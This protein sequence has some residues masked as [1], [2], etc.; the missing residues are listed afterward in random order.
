[1]GKLSFRYM[2]KPKPSRINA[3]KYTGDKTTKYGLA[4]Q[5]YA[6]LSDASIF[7]SPVGI[8]KIAAGLSNLRDLF[9][10]PL[11]Y[12]DT[13]I[14]EDFSDNPHDFKIREDQMQTGGMD[15]QNKKYIHEEQLKALYKDFHLSI[16]DTAMMVPDEEIIVN[17]YQNIFSN[18]DANH[19]KIYKDNNVQKIIG[20]SPDVTVRYWDFSL[21]FRDKPDF[22]ILKDIMA[23]PDTIDMRILRDISAWTGDP[24][25]NVI[26]QL[27]GDKKLHNPLMNEM[28]S[29]WRESPFDTMLNETIHVS[30]EITAD[31]RE[32]WFAKIN[33]IVNWYENISTA[34]KQI[35]ANRIIMK[36]CTRPIYIL[37]KDPIIDTWRIFKNKSIIPYLNVFPDLMMYQGNKTI[38]DMNKIF[39]SVKPE[40]KVGYFFNI[41][42]FGIQEMK[43]GLVMQDLQGNNG[44]KSMNVPYYEFIGWKGK[45][46]GFIPDFI[47]SGVKGGINGYLSYQELNSVRNRILGQ[48]ANKIVSY[49]KGGKEAYVTR[50]NILGRQGRKKTDTSNI[51][52]YILKD[53]V[54]VMPTQKKLLIQHL[55]KDSLI[56]DTMVSGFKDSKDFKILDDSTLFQKAGKDFKIK[57]TAICFQKIPNDMYLNLLHY[58]AEKQPKDFKILMDNQNAYKLQ[59]DIIIFRKM[60]GMDCIRQRH[61]DIGYGGIDIKFMNDMDNPLF[62]AKKVRDLSMT[63]KIIPASR[64][65]YFSNKH[66]DLLAKQQLKESNN[67]IDKNMWGSV[68]PKPTFTDD[69]GAF[70][71]KDAFQCYIDIQNEWLIKSKIKSDIANGVLFADKEQKRANNF[72]EA[73]FSRL[74]VDANIG[75]QEFAFKKDKESFIPDNT[76][77]TSRSSKDVYDF[78]YEWLNKNP[79]LGYYSYGLYMDKEGRDMDILKDSDMTEKERYGMVIDYNSMVTKN[80]NIRGWIDDV[81]FTERNLKDIDIYQQSEWIQRTNSKLALRP[82]DFGNWAWV[83]E[84]PDPLEHAYGI[85]ELLLPEEDVH[86]ENMEDIIFDKES[87]RPRNPIKVIDDTTF[88][89]RLPIRHPSKGYFDDIAKD[90]DASAIKWENYYGIRTEIMRTCFLKYYRIWETKMFEFSTMTMQQSVNQMLEYMYAWM[91]DYFPLDELQEAFRVLRLIRWYGES[92]VIQNSQYIISYEY[93]ILESKITTG[94][95]H[96]PNNLDTNDTMVIDASKGIIKNNPKYIGKGTAYVEFYID[97]KK[98]T[99]FTF[100]LS[101]T[102]G[103]VNIYIND[104][105]IDQKSFSALNLTYELPS[106][107]DT[108]VIRIEK[109]AA[110]NLNSTFFIGNIKVPDCAFKELSIEFDPKLRAGNKPIDAVAKKMIKFAQLHENSSEAYDMLFKKNLGVNEVYNKLMEYWKLH[111]E[112]KTKGKR[113]TIK[114]S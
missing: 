94:K 73:W 9:V 109:P 20:G 95:C 17:Y 64:I 3:F 27:Y 84:T 53:R 45:L 13:D 78:K 16:N 88:I 18:R 38:S 23:A 30:K 98:N 36:I 33:K 75:I 72:R 7:N 55:P 68:I 79:V 54:M 2:V 34:K 108:N 21:I 58:W 56:N 60:L 91:I 57:D 29:A 14:K 87:M 105:L 4:Y 66:I 112:N 19:M 51:G 28:F 69:V 24:V 41:D 22:R 59:K 8:T 113:L 99:T 63:T 74:P 52:A 47:D 40:D 32:Q 85:D 6:A 101:N 97:N 80:P 42:T 46:Q 39:Y 1:M 67:L 5:R 111:H 89:A 26:Y 86:Y 110:H 25:G 37:N 44:G 31:I 103:S 65:N 12:A 90:Y 76:A 10:T 71:D 102:V 62:G 81:V 15:R 82:D 93:D 106:I 114:K 70:M 100:S 49:D 43:Y 61:E 104:R 50:E 77:W 48:E 83:Y 107:G 92:A 11:L 96:V 35:I